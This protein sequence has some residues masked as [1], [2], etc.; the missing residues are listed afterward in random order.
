[1]FEGIKIYILVIKKI[2]KKNILKRE[3]K[4]DKRC[5]QS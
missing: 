3:R 4:R 5:H 2:E 1:M